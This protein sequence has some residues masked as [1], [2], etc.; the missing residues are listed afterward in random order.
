MITERQIQSVGV[1]GAGAWG[2]ALAITA[3]RAGRDVRLWAYEMETVEEINN[4]H[5]NR[6]FLPG[7]TLD[8]AVKATGRLDEA[9]ACD[10]ILLAVPAQYTRRIASGLAPLVAEG[11]AVVACAKGFEQSTGKLMTDVLREELPGYGK[12]GGRGR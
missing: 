3:H 1:I 9:A 8:P 12:S 5:S 10:L 7:V 2:T 11:T 4:H 6:V